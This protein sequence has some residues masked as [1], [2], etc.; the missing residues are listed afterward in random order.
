MVEGT[1]T[2]ELLYKIQKSQYN[3]YIIHFNDIFLLAGEGEK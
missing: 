1:S 3:W 2:P